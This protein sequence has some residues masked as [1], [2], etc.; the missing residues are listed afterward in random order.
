MD[1]RPLSGA[2]TYDA[3]GG[4]ILMAHSIMLRAGRQALSFE[5]PFAMGAVL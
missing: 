1:R 3:H 5:L 2:Y 4:Y